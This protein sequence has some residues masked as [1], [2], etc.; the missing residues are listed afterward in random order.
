M[1][2][3]TCKEC[4]QKFMPTRAMQPV[5]SNFQCMIDYSNKHLSK[6]KSLEKK[7]QRKALKK[8]NDSDLNLLKRKAQA[9]F[10][11]FI[12]LRDAKENCISCG[13]VMEDAEGHASH[14]K[15]STNSILRFDERNVHKSCV[16]C[17]IF[18]SGNLAA[19]RIALVNKLG[20]QTVEELESINGAYK[21]SVDELQNVIDTYRDK[22]KGLR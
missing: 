4:K 12:R 16:K 10:N 8:F 1:K 3:K 20:L 2:E 7:V 15:P 6:A 21:F 9:I 22:I 11:K 5:C 18:L 17:N 14:Y 13:K 19:Y